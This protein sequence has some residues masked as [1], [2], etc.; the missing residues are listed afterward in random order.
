MVFTICRKATIDFYVYFVPAIVFEDDYFVA[1]AISLYF[2]A[3]V[4]LPTG[5]NHANLFRNP[6]N[7]RVA[8][9]FGKFTKDNYINHVL[10]FLYFLML[11]NLEDL[12]TWERLRTR[13]QAPP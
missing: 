10:Y 7:L 4:I 5:I 12:L 13:P 3:S 1:K 8:M 6:R 11:S 2:M 9:S